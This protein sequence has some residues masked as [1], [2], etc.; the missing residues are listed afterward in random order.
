[1]YRQVVIHPVDRDFQR[2]VFL[3]QDDQPIKH[4]RLCTATYGTQCAAYP[5]IEAYAAVVYTRGRNDSEEIVVNLLAAKTRVAPIKQVALPRLEL[6]RSSFTVNSDGIDNASIQPSGSGALDIYRQQHRSQMVIRS[7][8]QMENV[9]G[10]SYVGNLGSAGI[11]FEARTTQQT[12]GPDE[13][14]SEAELWKRVPVEQADDEELLELP[15]LKVLHSAIP[16]IRT[17]YDIETSLLER[18]S[19]YMLIVRTLAYVNRFLLALKVDNEN[20]NVGLSPNEIYDAKIQLARAAQYAAYKPEL[21]L[22]RVGGRLQNS[23]YP[24]DVKHPVILPANYKVSELL[25]RDIHLRNLHAG[26]SLLAATVNSTR[27][28]D[29]V[30]SL[31]VHASCVRGVKT[32]KGYIVVFV[33]M[34]TKA[35][36]LEVAS[37]LST[38]TFVCA[39]KRFISRRSHPNEIWSDCGTNFVGKDHCLEDIQGAKQS[40]NEA[41]GRFLSNLGIK[42][43][44]NPPSAPHCGGIWEAAVKSAQIHLV[45]VLGAEAATYE[46]LSTVLALKPRSKWRTT[47]ANVEKDQLVLVKNGSWRVLSS[48]TRNTRT[49][50]ESSGQLRCGVVKRSTPAPYRRSACYRRIETLVPQGGGGCSHMNASQ[51]C[52]AYLYWLTL[53][54]LGQRYQ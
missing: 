18:H 27:C 34:A 2:I 33:C 31:K 52:R 8:P 7:P 39:L 19:N 5:A 12:C 9:R 38:N 23:A 6:K 32:T 10:Q 54:Q 1:M 30:G 24:Y 42:W 37:D 14:T 20:L 3:E 11:T 50:Q 46:D 26:P 22:M 53:A 49:R 43:V 29:Y 17:N 15:R 47:K 25:L 35:V 28:V 13:L 40:H 51:P 21:E 41:A 44:F 4:Y 48:N 45:A 36:H 16:I